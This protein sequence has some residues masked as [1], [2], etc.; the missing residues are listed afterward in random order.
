MKLRKGELQTDMGT[1]IIVAKRGWIWIGDCRKD[2][3]YIIVKNAL[4]I[5]RWG[6]TRGLGE[7]LDG[8]TGKTV[9]DKYGTVQVYEPN[10]VA[11]MP[12]DRDKWGVLDG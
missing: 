8:P 4:N 10:I 2:G 5:R 9:L 3:N 7:L 1:A 12:V 6:T 11:I